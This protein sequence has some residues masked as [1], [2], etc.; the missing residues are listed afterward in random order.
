[1][2][3]VIGRRASLGQANGPEVELIV[4]GTADYANYETP[5]GYPV[6]YDESLGLFCF[7]RVENGEYH[8]T[9]V[10]VS[11]PAPSGVTR[12][13]RE[14]DMVRARKINDRQAQRELR[15]R[16]PLAKE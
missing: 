16:G 15:A 14:S 10:S 12:H 3:G 6:V 5:D 9:Q 13:A 1:M 2:S 8:S 11:A 4:S 7:A